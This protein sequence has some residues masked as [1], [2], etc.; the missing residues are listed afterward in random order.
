[1]IYLKKSIKQHLLL[2]SIKLNPKYMSKETWNLE[3][4]RVLH[5][6]RFSKMCVNKR[7]QCRPVGY[8]EFCKEIY[9]RL[10]LEDVY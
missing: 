10:H 3:K 7:G 9:K 5:L 6:T 1:M 4:M 2:E 8:P